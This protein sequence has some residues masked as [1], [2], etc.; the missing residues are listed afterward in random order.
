MVVITSNNIDGDD[1]I[2]NNNNQN[3]NTDDDDDDDVADESGRSSIRTQSST[4]NINNMLDESISNLSQSTQSLLR[5]ARLDIVVLGSQC[6]DM[7]ETLVQLES[8]W[9][10]LQKLLAEDA[11]RSKLEEEEE[12]L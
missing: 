2:N 11:E 8:Q 10:M 6:E 4:S 9:D 1:N 12:I 3:N 5:T 7:K